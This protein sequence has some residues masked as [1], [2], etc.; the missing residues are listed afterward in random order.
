MLCVP[1]RAIA[2]VARALD[3]SAP[4]L[5]CSGATDLQP[6]QHL[7]ERG[8]LHPLM[9]FP[10]PELGL[11]DLAG[12]PAAIDGTPE[13]LR[14][15]EQLAFDLGLRPVRITGDRRLYHAAAVLAGNFTTVLLAQAAA[16]L[17]PLGLDEAE[18]VALLR[19]LALASVQNAAP[20]PARALTG[21]A[22]RGDL[23][24]LQ[25][26]QRA[27]TEHGLTEVGEVYALLARRALSLAAAGPNRSTPCVAGMLPA[28]SPVSKD[29]S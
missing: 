14:L 26:H 8:S 22:A 9:S 15:A 5:H 10:G 27:L 20:S 23:T 24:T 16:A 25:N 6:L 4:V 7:P 1:D 2:E 28:G 29:R 11:P 12:V 13:A 19:P 17:A 18:A 3:G 21:P